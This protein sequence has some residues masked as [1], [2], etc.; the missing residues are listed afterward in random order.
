MS[1]LHYQPRGSRPAAQKLSE[2]TA[3][4]GAPADAAAPVA[5]F[6]RAELLGVRRFAG[7][8]MGDL[9]R[10]VQRAQLD[11]RVPRSVLQERRLGARMITA[12]LAATVMAIDGQL[13]QQNLLAE[14]PE[15]P[16][17]EPTD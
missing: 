12:W 1:I 2:A 14:Q 3:A 8:A 4:S 10:Q 13:Q 11:P 17:V 9:Q 5:E 15:E 7:V 16:I 6:T